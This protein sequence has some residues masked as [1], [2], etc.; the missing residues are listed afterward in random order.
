MSL[1][2]LRRAQDRI[3][4]EAIYL[5]RL[6]R[7]KIATPRSGGARNDMNACPTANLHIC[8]DAKFGRLRLVRMI[9]L[10]SHDRS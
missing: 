7:F 3:E 5:L 8:T 4:G 1:R 2:V 9:F 6:L 10:P